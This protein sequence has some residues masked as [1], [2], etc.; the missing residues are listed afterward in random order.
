LELVIVLNMNKFGQK[1]A[2]AMPLQFHVQM[3]TS[4]CVANGT[5]S[6]NLRLDVVVVGSTLYVTPSNCWMTPAVTL[7]FASAHPGGRTRRY[8]PPVHPP[9]RTA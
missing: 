2:L 6:G 9:Y 4:S 3:R 1:V 8:A 5:R 7:T